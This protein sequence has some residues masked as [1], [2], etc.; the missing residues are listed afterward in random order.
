MARKID[1]FELDLGKDVLEGWQRYYCPLNVKAL[2]VGREMG[3]QLPSVDVVKENGIYRLVFGWDYGSDKEDNYG[4]HSRARLAWEDGFLLACDIF[5]D[6][7]SAP[8]DCEKDIIYKSIKEISP[9]II[10]R[11]IELQLR[12]TLEYLP[13]KM[14]KKFIEENDLVL[15]DGD[16]LMTGENF[17]NPPPF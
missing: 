4:G 16:V 7:R 13:K 8:E 11:T 3:H 10:G 5:D 1:E 15:T 14:K 12:R 2:R 9:R 6:H 17:R